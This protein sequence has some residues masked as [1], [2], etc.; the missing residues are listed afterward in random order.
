MKTCKLDFCKVKQH[1][2]EYC[3]KH[4]AQMFRLGK[5]LKKTKFDKNEFIDKGDYYEIALY[6]KENKEIARALVDKEDYEEVKGYRWRIGNRGYVLNKKTTLHQFI[7]GKKKGLEIDHINHNKLDN[8]SQNLRHCTG[9]Q[10]QMNNNAKGYRWNESNNKW[11]AGIVVN[12]RK[13][14]LGYFKNEEDA[15]KAREDAKIKYFGEY[16]FKSIE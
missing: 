13:I 11:R 1:A 8:R 6:N 9:S 5:I 12:K 14:N 10:N 3:A 16:R 15:K 7:L 4:Y 2:K